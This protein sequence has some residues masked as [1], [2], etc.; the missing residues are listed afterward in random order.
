MVKAAQYNFVWSLYKAY[1]PQG[2]HCALI[3]VQGLVLSTL[4]K[5]LPSLWSASGTVELTWW[6][7]D[8]YVKPEA[9]VTTPKNI[10]EKTWELFEQ[11]RGK[12]DLDVDIVD[13]EYKERRKE[14]EAQQQR[15]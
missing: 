12:F 11:E 5:P 1:A 4:C 8:R 6:T 7:I 15:T 2:V 13:P 10:A 14:L 9:Q 3:V